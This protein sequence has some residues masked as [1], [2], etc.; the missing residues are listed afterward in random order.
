MGQKSK[1]VWRFDGIDI[2]V[3]GFGFFARNSMQ[4]P[5][6][7]SR[8]WCTFHLDKYCTFTVSVCLSFTEQIWFVPLPLQNSIE[9]KRIDVRDW[10]SCHAWWWWKRVNLFIPPRIEK[11]I[12]KTKNE[13][14][15]SGT[16]RSLIQ[17]NWAVAMQFRV[18]K[19]LNV[20]IWSVR[21]SETKIHF[22]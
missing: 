20:R 7:L 13:N 14:A 17:S 3:F 19:T 8:S 10:P 9:I 18:P 11:R 1:I 21:S 4:W 16:F 12:R 22:N 6:P 5:W 2:V 15:S